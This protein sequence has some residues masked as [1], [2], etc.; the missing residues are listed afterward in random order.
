MGPASEVSR[1]RISAGDDDL[2]CCPGV[3]VGAVAA[4][5][6]PGFHD[7]LLR[8]S[9]HPRWGGFRSL[10]SGHAI[11]RATQVCACSH[12]A[13][14]AALSS[15]TVRGTPVRSLYAAGLLA[16][17]P[18]LD[19]DQPAPHRKWRFFLRDLMSEFL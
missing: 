16:G 11:S 15:P 2:Q 8:R 9:F 5:W 7:F 12:P 6:I 17:L 1:R 10:R 14:T 4:Q 18:A 3:S 13:R 19:R